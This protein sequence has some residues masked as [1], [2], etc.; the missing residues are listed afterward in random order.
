LLEILGLRALLVAAPFAVWF[1]WREV[2]RR[3]G[4]AMGST[5]WAWLFAIGA[6]LMGGSLMATAIFHPD[7]R[8]EVYV[9]GE[10]MADGSVS[11][12][13]FEQKKPIQR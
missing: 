12:A 10:P 3:S 13:H 11:S 7:N 1:I 6:L 2:A 8:G 4:R 9:P 5:P